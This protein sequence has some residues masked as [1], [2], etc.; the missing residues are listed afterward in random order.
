MRIKSVD[1][2]LYRIDRKAEWR[3]ISLILRI[4]NPLKFP[5][6]WRFHFDVEKLTVD[7]SVSPT[8]SMVGRAISLTPHSASKIRL[9][10]WVLTVPE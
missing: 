9:L 4:F 10:P 5:P 1:R 7:T 2:D 6:D 3:R 8:A